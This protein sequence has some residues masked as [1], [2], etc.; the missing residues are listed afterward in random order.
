MSGE[1]RG[2][3]G[4]ATRSGAFEEREARVEAGR[5]AVK[6]EEART[7]QAIKAVARKGIPYW[8]AGVISQLG[9]SPVYLS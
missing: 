7:G 1:A 9:T 2:S 8:G 4:D 5:S 3:G 6:L